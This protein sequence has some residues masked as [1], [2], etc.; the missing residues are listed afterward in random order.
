MNKETNEEEPESDPEEKIITDLP[1]D[2]V[3]VV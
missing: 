2:E 3:E 1:E